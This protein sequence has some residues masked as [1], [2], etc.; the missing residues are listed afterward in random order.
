MHT[1]YGVKKELQEPRINADRRGS[2]KTKK[3]NATLET[4]GEKGCVAYGLTCSNPRYS[5]QI[6]GRIFLE[7]SA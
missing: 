5:A 7:H 3:Y 4:L 2:E 6:R 1:G